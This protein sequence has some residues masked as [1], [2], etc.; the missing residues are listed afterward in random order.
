[1]TVLA[2]DI[3]GTKTLLQVVESALGGYGVIFER[4]YESAA[5]DQFLP[6]VSDFLDTA[7]E[8][9]GARI[10]S[11]C[12]GVAGPVTG[13]KAKTTNLPWSLDA[14]ELERVLGIPRVRLI[15]DFQA[16]GYGIEAL[17]AADLV[18]LQAGQPQAHGPRVVIGAGTGLGHGILVW[19][20]DHYEV[21]ASEGGH[22]DFAPTDALQIELLRYLQTR[23]GLATWER[24][25]SG[26]GLVNL[27]DFLRQS[28]TEAETDALRK[29]RT[30][31]ED[32]AATISQFALSGDDALAVRSLDLWVRL[33]GARA[34]NFALTCLPTG[35]VYV[36]GGIAPKIVDKLKDGTFVDS[37]CEREPRMRALLEATAVHVVINS[38]V[39]IM[40]AALVAD[41]SRRSS[42]FA[43]SSDAPAR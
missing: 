43:I 27:F 41:R 21:V 13:R 37:F 31:S 10:Q 17:G 3:G 9:T 23:Y 33:Y 34:G 32:V 11:A 35:G 38:K 4:R 1:M 20:Q 6:L 24:V 36:A 14:T 19:H 16:V 22:A 40:G 18:T 12:F 5:Y 28:G 30:K 15:N 7:S 8:Q 2:G 25:V 42:P 29:A 26:P 39:G